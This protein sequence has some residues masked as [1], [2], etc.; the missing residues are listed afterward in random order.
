M[1]NHDNKNHTRSN[2]SIKNEDIQKLI[3]EHITRI[4]DKEKQ[5]QLHS[6]MMSHSARNKAIPLKQRLLQRIKIRLKE[7]RGGLGNRDKS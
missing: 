1:N 4:I 7:I 2:S 5:E 6:A 3:D